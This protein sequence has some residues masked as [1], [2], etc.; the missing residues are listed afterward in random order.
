MSW[1]ILT[2]WNFPYSEYLEFLSV[3]KNELLTNKN[4]RY[5]LVC[6]H[7]HCF[8]HGR[9]LRSLKD[10]P[11]LIH[12]DEKQTHKLPYELFS[13]NRGGGLTF[14]YPGQ[15]IIYPM[16]NLNVFPK[17][18][19]TLMHTLLITTGDTLK[20]LNILSEYQIPKDIY[21]LW[22]N[23]KKIASIG[24]GLDHY[25]TEHGLALNFY[26]DEEMFQHL[27]QLYPCGLSA[28]TY[29]SVEKIHE[30]NSLNNREIFVDLFIK[31]FIRKF[32]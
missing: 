17:A 4:K 20:E 10:G 31:N 7:P 28:K 8:T 30:T 1:E 26:H 15:I 11:N 13:I 25:V 27:N 21:G 5:L 16:V 18:L 32:S 23:N 12:Y 2:H 14:H 9:G 6:S 29:G 3:K 19:M 22:S 24:M